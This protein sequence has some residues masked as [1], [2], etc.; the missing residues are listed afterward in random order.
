MKKYIRRSTILLVFIVLVASCHQA[1]PR[2]NE[3]DKIIVYLQLSANLARPEP[4]NYALKD[5]MEIEYL[6]VKNTEQHAKWQS[7][8]AIVYN[9]YVK[10]TL[11]A[12]EPIKMNYGFGSLP[13]VSSGD[14]IVIRYNGE[15]Y[16]YSG[17][18]SEKLTCWNEMLRKGKETVIPTA[19]NNYLRSLDDYFTWMSHLDNKITKQISL[20]ES[21]K[22]KISPFEFEYLKV[23]AVG[24]MENDRIQVFRALRSYCKKDSTAHISLSDLNAI[25][26]STQYHPLNT[27]QQTISNYYADIYNISE[28]NKQEVWRA[29]GFNANNDSLKSQEQR[30]NLYYTHAKQKYNGLLRER[31]LAKIMEDATKKG[32]KD[33]ITQMMFKDYYN[34]P[35]FPEYKKQVKELEEKVAEKLAKK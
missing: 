27:W 15:E 4:K 11:Y 25:W 30:N 19:S 17:K 7:V 32:L 13:V 33:P 35:G 23:T 14:S 20:L 28:F 1:E 10:W 18:G 3:A 9:G 22:D 2:H 24:S 29:F 5:K 8:N 31:V 26:D 34:Q 12:T 6:P 21:F 16:Q